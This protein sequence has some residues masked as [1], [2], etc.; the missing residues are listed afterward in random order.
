MEPGPHRSPRMGTLPSSEPGSAILDTDLHGVITAWNTDAQQ[1]FGYTATEAV[2]RPL[3]FLIPPGRHSEQDEL[4]ARAAH[5]ETIDLIE[6]LGTRRDGSL[7]PIALTVTALRER[8][9]RHRRRLP[10]RRAI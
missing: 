7:V 1:L 5:G 9:R 10:R 4:T 8:R 2:G 3:N 6:T